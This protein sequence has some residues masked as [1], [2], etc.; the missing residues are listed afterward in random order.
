MKYG[1]IYSSG[2]SCLKHIYASSVQHENI[3]NVFVKWLDE[4]SFRM[5]HTDYPYLIG[6][7]SVI[8]PVTVSTV[9]SDHL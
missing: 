4:C 2:V 8:M 6:D 5:G 1:D 9:I 3:F 7:I